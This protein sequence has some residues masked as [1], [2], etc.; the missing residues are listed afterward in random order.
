VTATCVRRD[1][2]ESGEDD[3][4]KRQTLLRAW[5]RKTNKSMLC[6]WRVKSLSKVCRLAHILSFFFFFFLVLCIKSV[7]SKSL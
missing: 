1:D 4:K 7:L 5:L 2:T 6:K 3:V